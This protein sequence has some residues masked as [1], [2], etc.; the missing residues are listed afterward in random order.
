[1]RE[2]AFKKGRSGFDRAPTPS[3]R[4]LSIG[5]R[6][7]LEYILSVKT[8]LDVHIMATNTFGQRE[9]VSLKSKLRAIM[10]KIC[11]DFAT[12]S[13]VRFGLIS[14]PGS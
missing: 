3:S 9:V 4:E 12:Y 5:K 13:N 11:L 6:S 8:C 1:M 14:M 10:D 2:S 7:T